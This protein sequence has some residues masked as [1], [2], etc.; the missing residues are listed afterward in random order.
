MLQ[1]AGRGSDDPPST[2]MW[3]IWKWISAKMLLL[4]AWSPFYFL[5]TRSLSL[6]LCLSCSS[7]SFVAD[8]HYYV[9]AI[10]KK[11]SVWSLILWNSWFNVIE[12]MLYT[13]LCVM[14]LV[15]SFSSAA[16]VIISFAF[17]PFNLTDSLMMVMNHLTL[18][19]NKSSQACLLRFH[20]SLE[21]DHRPVIMLIFFTFFFLKKIIEIISFSML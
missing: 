10:C 21:R 7:S 8:F 16:S 4:L 5:T 14:N 18:S 12:G 19:T 20:A 6:S 3:S 1:L 13:L 9:A 2:G 17:R 11:N 15:M